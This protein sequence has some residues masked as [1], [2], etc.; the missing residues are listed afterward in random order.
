MVYLFS[1]ELERNAQ[2]KRAQKESEV[3]LEPPE[4]KL[5]IIKRIFEQALPQRELIIGGGKVETKAKAAGGAIYNAAEMSD[6]ERVI[7]YLAGQAL[8]APHDGILIIDEPELHLH[9][10]IQAKLWDEI[11]AERS[12]CLFVYLTHDLEFASTRI[13]AKKYG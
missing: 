9:K 1:E 12:D 4:T 6:G 7:F 10:S 11:A 5:D 3:R 13:G 8:A 2:Y